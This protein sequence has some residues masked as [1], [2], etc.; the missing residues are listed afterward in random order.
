[1][2]FNPGVCTFS[3]GRGASS[4]PSTRHAA[5]GARAQ[6]ERDALTAISVSPA[7]AGSTNAHAAPA[8]ASIASAGKMS[9]SP[10]WA[11]ARTA[12]A[13]RPVAASRMAAS[14]RHSMWSRASSASRARIGP[15][16]R[17]PSPV[18]VAKA[19]TP[20]GSCVYVP[21]SVAYR[22]CTRS[23][24]VHCG[25]SSPVLWGRRTSARPA[26]SKT[27]R[28]TSCIRRCTRTPAGKSA[29]R[30]MPAGRA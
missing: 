18:A 29:K 7:G 14:S 26:D 27:L 21:I 9:G 25:C 28:R 3:R 13:A 12:R 24:S 6:Y 30:P 8:S 4:Q 1:M 10:N 11:V 20:Q 5:H 2:V 19:N 17:S 23:S 15:P 22:R 16:P